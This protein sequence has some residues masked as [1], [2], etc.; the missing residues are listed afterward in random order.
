MSLIV[1]ISTVADNN[2]FIPDDRSNKDIA[3]HRAKF[4]RKHAITMEQS[5]RVNITYTTDDF[6]RY[7]EV[8]RSQQGLGM[9]NDDITPADALITTVS[10]H[11]LFL[12]LADCVGAV[13]YDPVRQVLMVSHLGRHS[14]EQFGGTKSVEYLKDKYGCKPEDILVWLTPS[15]GKESYPMW[16]FDNRSI[17]SVVIEQLTSAGILDTHITDNPADTT[18]DS[19]Y[20]SHSEFLAGRRQVDGRHCIVAMIV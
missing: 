5:T 15:P 14:T 11:A 16:A 9:Y 13:L 7:H 10:H 2:M 8:S 1:A 17:K 6:C 18:K 12:P 4:L 20:F 3:A 19:R